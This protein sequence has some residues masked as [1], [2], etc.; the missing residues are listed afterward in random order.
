MRMVTYVIRRALLLVPVLFGV[1]TITFLLFT[2]LPVSTQILSDLGPPNP[3]NLCQYQK[4]CPCN[5]ENP[6]SVHGTHCQCINPTV[7]TTP[8]GLCSNPVYR[9]A[10]HK[11]GLDR[12][13]P[14]QWAR[15]IY[16]TFTFRWGFAA[17]HSFIT[18][19]EPYI[20]GVAV[21]TILSWFLPWTLELAMLSLG[22]I[23]LIAIPLGNA[24]AVNRN[25]PIDQTARVMSFSGFA[26][27]AF[28]LGSVLVAGVTIL[29]LGHFGT[30]NIVTPWCHGGQG[31]DLQFQYSLPKG[32][33]C[34][35]NPAVGCNYPAW[36]SCAGTSTH[37]T[38]FPTVDAIL[39]GQYWLA[40]D[41]I[42]RMLMPA[43][44]VAYGTIAALLRF[45]RNS[46]LEV[47]NL[48]YV[49]TARAKGVPEKIVTSKHAGRNSLNVTITVLGLTFAAF[50]SGFPVVEDVFKLNGVGRTIA[51][52]V[53][54]N[55]DY[56]IIFGST[57]LFTWLV[58]AAN[59]IVDVLYAYLDPRVRL[60]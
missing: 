12:P 54:P 35:A 55:L 15:Y 7:N 57:L 58:V 4:T 38:G 6:I 1:V 11:L 59:I 27:P 43:F 9:Q 42:I 56:G 14:E 32:I 60:G 39:H 17:N 18:Q 25:R 5:L 48:D 28:L 46:M 50:I 52:A 23:L 36:I 40:L 41:T 33:Q 26:I 3:H 13:L 47:M 34:Y 24:A 30:G 31:I 2:A 45:V 19:Q 20:G 21:I 51:L 16:N 53:V 10:V 22:I 44:V 49:R 29:L 37:P 8:T